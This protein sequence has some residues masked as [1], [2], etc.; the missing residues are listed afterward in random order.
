MP[1][2]DTLAKLILDQKVVLVTIVNRIE[3]ADVTP[4][5][6]VQYGRSAL[7]QG[8][9]RVTTRTLRF[10]QIEKFIMENEKVSFTGVDSTR[11]IS[12][13]RY[14]ISQQGRRDA[15]WKAI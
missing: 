3:V 10:A 13:R 12:H 8:E 5:N 6:R 15:T 7:Y 2:A 9:L 4:L 14:E 11:S 1:E